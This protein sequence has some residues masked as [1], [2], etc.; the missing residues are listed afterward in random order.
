MMS[1]QEVVRKTPL[2]CLKTV[3]LLAVERIGIP[4]NS[5]KTDTR[6]KADEVSR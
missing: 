2:H 3:I 5:E 4:Q 6:M 1:K